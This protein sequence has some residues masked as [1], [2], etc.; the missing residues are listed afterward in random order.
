MTDMGWGWR[1]VARWLGEG[2]EG[3]PS[4]ER[5]YPDMRLGWD[6]I[7]RRGR[8]GSPGIGEAQ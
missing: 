1:E 6:Y 3:Y 4:M 5:G 7:A 8:G 2:E